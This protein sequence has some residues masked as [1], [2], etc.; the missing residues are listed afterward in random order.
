MLSKILDFNYLIQLLT[1]LSILLR[2]YLIKNIQII[3]IYYMCIIKK[4]KL[5]NNFIKLSMKINQT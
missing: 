5:I 1:I 2:I 4:E 3:D